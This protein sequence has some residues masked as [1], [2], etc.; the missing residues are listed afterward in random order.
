MFQIE[1]IKDDKC[2]TPYLEVKK[3]ST[4][5]QVLEIFEVSRVDKY[6]LHMPPKQQQALKEEAFN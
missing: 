6:V 4:V 3:I 2:K 1:I 5:L